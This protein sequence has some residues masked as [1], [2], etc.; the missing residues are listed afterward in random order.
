MLGPIFTYGLFVFGCISGFRRPWIGIVIFFVFATLEPTWNW[1]WAI[2][3]TF[4]YQKYLAFSTLLGF[5]LSGFKFLPFNS[6]PRYA[7]FALIGFLALAFLAAQFTINAEFTRRYM[8]VLWKVVAMNLLVL[9]VIDDRRKLWILMWAIVLSQGYNAYQINMDYFQVGYSRYAR[10]DWGTKGDNN[11]YSIFTIPVMGLACGLAVY[12]EKMW[13]KA[14]AVVVFVFQAH[15]IMLLDSRGSMIGALGLVVTFLIFMPK[16]FKIIATVAS[17]TIIVA[18]L[19][20]P[21]V[22]QEFSSSFKASGERDSSAEGR[23]DLWKAGAAITA[24]Y[25]LLGVGPYAGQ[26]LVP[27]YYT[28]S[29]RKENKGLHNLFFEISTGCGLPAAVLYVAFFFLLWM[30]CLLARYRFK[31][32][33]FSPEVNAAFLAVKCGIPSYWLA[34]MFS[35]GALLE[36]SYLLAVIGG[37]ALIVTQQEAMTVLEDDDQPVDEEHNGLE[38]TLEEA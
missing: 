29:D 10:R 16:N 32:D 11:V 30:G 34:S 36:T 6:Y 22:M 12:S 38:N 3:T 7:A 13:Q 20:G 24:D 2:D 27:Q 21:S 26:F 23:F 4:P 25:P 1:R 18:A 14:L 33:L 5:S 17:T 31:Q 35:S 28:G 19:A 37:V 9:L 15:Q 8:D